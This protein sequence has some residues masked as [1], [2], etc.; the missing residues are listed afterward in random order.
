MKVVKAV[1]NWWYGWD[2]PAY[3][4]Y[5]IRRWVDIRLGI[6]GLLT[7]SCVGCSKITKDFDPYYEWHICNNCASEEINYNRAQ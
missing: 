5:K 1:K 4:L 3:K 2:G 7:G 6:L